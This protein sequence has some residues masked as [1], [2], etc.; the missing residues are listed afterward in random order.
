MI[1]EREKMMDN[2]N[3]S[4]SIRGGKEDRRLE[5]RRGQI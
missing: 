2:F 3:I 1:P 5:E 4:P